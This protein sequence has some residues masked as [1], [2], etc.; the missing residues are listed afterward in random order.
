MVNNSTDDEIVAPRA[1]IHASHNQKPSMHDEAHEAQTACCSC[2]QTSHTCHNTCRHACHSSV[3]GA[4]VKHMTVRLPPS[5]ST[6][7]VA[8]VSQGQ[9]PRSPVHTITSTCGLPVAGQNSV[10]VI[11]AT[12]HATRHIRVTHRVVNGVM[13]STCCP[14]ALA[15]VSPLTRQRSQPP[16]VTSPITCN[17][18]YVKQR[19]PAAAAGPPAAPSCQKLLRKPPAQ[20]Q[21]TSS[22]EP[23]SKQW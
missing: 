11:R 19:G 17:S 7:W 13:P 20:A 9:P 14:G 21:H 23:V 5:E 18:V 10:P 1:T 16:P 3:S 2:R 22:R 12:A 6:A 15:W 8:W 4:C